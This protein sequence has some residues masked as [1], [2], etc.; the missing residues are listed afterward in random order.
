MFKYILLYFSLC[1]CVG[2]NVYRVGRHEKIIEVSD[3]TVKNQQRLYFL[4]KRK[5]A[6]L[7]CDK[8]ELLSITDYK[9][10]CLCTYIP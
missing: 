1:S 7:E 4:A 5:A 6:L 9:I 3:S 10:V 8:I 2:Y